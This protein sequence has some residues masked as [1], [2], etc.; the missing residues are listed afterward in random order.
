MQK[1]KDVKRKQHI[2]F[3][4]FTFWASA[5]VVITLFT[6]YA[7][8]AKPPPPPVLPIVTA[9]PMAAIPGG[10][11]DITFAGDSLGKPL[12]LWTSFGAGATALQVAGKGKVGYN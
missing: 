10:S 3:Y 5:F 8:S 9:S 11:T 4:V 12:G 2:T 7:W 6:Q 1:R